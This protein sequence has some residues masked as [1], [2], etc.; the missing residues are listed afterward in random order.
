M[1][2]CAQNVDSAGSTAAHSDIVEDDTEGTDDE[3]WPDR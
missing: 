3:Y 1:C 2:M